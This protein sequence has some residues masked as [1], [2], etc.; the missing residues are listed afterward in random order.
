MNA[1]LRFL[2]M[3]SA[4]MFM[5]V[6][7]TAHAADGDAIQSH[8]VEVNGLTLHYLKAAKGNETPVVLLH[9]YAQTSHM[10]RPLMPLLSDRRAVIAPDLRG[11]GSSSTPDGGYDKKTLAQDIHAL[12][13]VAR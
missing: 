9:G 8:G 11:A 7:P 4:A 3:A 6:Q 10:W 12:V 1:L 2:Q 13:A 5:M